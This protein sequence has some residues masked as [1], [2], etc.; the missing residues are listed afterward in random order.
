MQYELTPLQTVRFAEFVM[1]ECSRYYC[2]NSA[3]T[4]RLRFKHRPGACCFSKRRQL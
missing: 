3:I 2:E 4:S 1:H